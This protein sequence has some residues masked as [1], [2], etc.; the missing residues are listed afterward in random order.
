MIS[1]TTS[2]SGRSGLSGVA[3]V[4]VVPPELERR[5]V[6]ALRE[7]EADARGLGEGLRVNARGQFA[8]DDVGIAELE[9]AERHVDGVAGHVAQGAGAE[10]IP[11]AP[12]ER[13]IDVLLEGP[14][15]GRAEP[16]IPVQV[17]RDRV[18][19]ARAVQALGPDRAVGPDMQFERFADHARLDDFDGAA[20]AALGAALVAHLRRQVLLFGQLPHHARLADGLDQR[21][22]AEAVFAHLHRPDRRHAVV[23]VRRGNGHR[24]D[25][26]AHFI[27]HLAVIAVL[28]GWGN[29][30]ANCLAFLPSV[31]LVHVADGHDVAAALRGVAAVAVAFAAHADAGDVDA[32]IGAQHPAHIGEGEGG[33]ARGQRGAAEELTASE[34]VRF[35]E[36]GY[37]V[38]LHVQDVL[39]RHAASV[40]TVSTAEGRG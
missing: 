37:S 7:L 33:R 30:S 31:L 8:L 9:R 3:R 23:M 10:I 22:L 35:G 5:Q 14:L 29:F 25:V 4:A 40:T 6:S 21:L 38:V 26:L 19:P 1:W 2:P 13:V 12:L 17:R 20:Q 34:G 11:A 16:E 24:I 27:Q 18:L 36:S 39:R 32:V 15:A 28:L